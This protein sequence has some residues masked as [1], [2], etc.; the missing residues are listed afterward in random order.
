MVRYESH[1]AYEIFCLKER[2]ALENRSI[3]FYA[4]CLRPADAPTTAGALKNPYSGPLNGT[5]ASL[6]SSSEENSSPTC[7]I[8]NL[9]PSDPARI[10]KSQASMNNEANDRTITLDV[11]LAMTAPAGPR[12]TLLHDRDGIVR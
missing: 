6:L 12:Q 11:T 10:I 8:V 1:R 4:E 7:E 2:Q 5:A 3:N 9:S